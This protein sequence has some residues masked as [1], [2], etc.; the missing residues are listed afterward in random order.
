MNKEEFEVSELG[1]PQ[2]GVICPLIANI[3]LNEFDQKMM[4]RGHR[5]VRYAEDILIFTCSKSAA[6]NALCQARAILEDDLKLIM[7]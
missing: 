1:S 6:E 7:N 2:V 3:Y 4:K 5:I